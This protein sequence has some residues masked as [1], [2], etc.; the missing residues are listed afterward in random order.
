MNPKPGLS[1]GPGDR[2]KEGVSVGRP[3]REDKTFSIFPA[4]E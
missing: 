2:D 4:S 1:S 3:F